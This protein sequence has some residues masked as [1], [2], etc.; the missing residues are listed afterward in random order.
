MELS[1]IFNCMII[2]LGLEL[3][4]NTSAVERQ[5]IYFFDFLKT[6]KVGFY[7]GF[8]ICIYSSHFVLYCTLNWNQ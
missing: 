1:S 5:L 6:F 8:S 2:C 3:L 4:L 7:E